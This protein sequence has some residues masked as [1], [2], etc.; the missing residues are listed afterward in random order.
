[1]NFAKFSIFTIIGAGLWNLILMG[2]GYFFNE[3]REMLI[4]NLKLFGV[5]LLVFVAIYIAYHIFAKRKFH[6]MQK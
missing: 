5:I 1:M 4:G 2:I 3:K 6:E